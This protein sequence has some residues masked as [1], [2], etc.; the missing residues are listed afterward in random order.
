MFNLQLGAV[1]I[2]I[3]LVKKDNCFCSALDKVSEKITNLGGK[4][5]SKVEELK[6]AVADQTTAITDMQTRVS[7]DVETLKQKIS[8][9]GAESPELTELLEN[10]KAN[11]AAIATLDPVVEALPTETTPEVPETPVEETPEV[12]PETPE[13][14]G[15]VVEEDTE[16]GPVNS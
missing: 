4:I 3:G 2:R 9:L 12:T 13:G 5:M 8:E 14:A 10:I 11:T 1:F 7:E 15:P 16:A 6:T